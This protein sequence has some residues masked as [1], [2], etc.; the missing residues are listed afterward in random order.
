MKSFIKKTLQV[1]LGFDNYLFLFSIFI[2]KTL[3]WNKNESDFLYFIAKIPEGGIVLDIGA[4]I[5]IMSVHLSKKLKSSHIY[6]FE[7]V[8]VNFKALQRI[9]RF[10]HLDNV[11]ILNFALGNKKGSLEMIMP[12]VNKVKMQGLSH[13]IHESIE[14]FN[15][16]K[17]INVNV[18]T[19][20]QFEHD[21]QPDR[22]ITAIKMDVENFEYF[23]LEGGK[24]LIAKHRPVIYT[25]LWDNENRNKCFELIKQFKYTIQVLIN[26]KLVDYNMDLHTTQNFFFIPESNN[27]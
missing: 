22:H 24:E 20:D 13:V 3:R 11:T 5:G 26:N 8:P 14:T 12:V 4:N 19:L 10:Y 16:G 15:E 23:V 21:L 1:L 17:K 6:A 7:P 9:I 18:I 27:L 2:I 25:E